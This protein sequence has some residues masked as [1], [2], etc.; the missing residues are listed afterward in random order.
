MYVLT[1]PQAAATL[2]V[3]LIGF[4]I[5]LFGTTLVNAVL[6]LILASIVLSALLAEKVIA[7][8]PA[9]VARVQ[10]LGSRVVVV[11][12]ST[13]PTDAAVRVATM[14]ARPDGGQS[15]LVITGT[16]GEPP[17]DGAVVRGVEKRLFRHGFEGHVRTEINDLPGAV[18]NAIV[19]ARPSLLV[20]DDPTFDSSPRRV[21]LLVVEGATPEPRQVRLIVDRDAADGLE[22]EIARRLTRAPRRSI[23]FR[24]GA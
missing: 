10:P 24:L 5:G 4:E 20:V 14:L 8:L 11:T 1:A 22:A 13:G 9:G 6:V 12:P 3:T 15:D 17:P 2:A 18:A 23:R 7:W 19:T 21:P 16:E